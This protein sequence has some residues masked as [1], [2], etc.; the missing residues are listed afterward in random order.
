M[1]VRLHLTANCPDLIP[2]SSSNSSSPFHQRNVNA[3]YTSSPSYSSDALL[4]DFTSFD[5][6]HSIE[7][8][9]YVLLFRN[10]GLYTFEEL[11]AIEFYNSVMPFLFRFMISQFKS[12]KVGLYIC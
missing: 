11:G 5:N 2:S 7:D 4:R 1:E 8:N 9:P 6:D 12:I 10:Y 3:V